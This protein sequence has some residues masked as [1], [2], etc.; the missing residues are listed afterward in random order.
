MIIVWI[1]I[2]FMYIVLTIYEY[3]VAVIEAR[4]RVIKRRIIMK[5]AIFLYKNSYICRVICIGAY[6]IE[7]C[8]ADNG[9][10]Y[11]RYVIELD[12]DGIQIINNDILLCKYES[13]V[14]LLMKERR[15]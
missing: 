8:M 9:Y 5:G 4:E 3:Y 1:S 6:E 10:V 7:L 13:Q 12:M 14:K 11:S 15:Y 2:L